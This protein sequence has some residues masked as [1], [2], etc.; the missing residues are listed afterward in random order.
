MVGVSRRM[1]ESSDPEKS[2]DILREE[3][4]FV[5]CAYLDACSARASLESASAIGDSDE[6]LSEEVQ[7]L[8]VVRKN[9]AKKFKIAAHQ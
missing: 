2:L 8:D 5:A 3:L 4:I 9:T 1:L 6:E 7:I